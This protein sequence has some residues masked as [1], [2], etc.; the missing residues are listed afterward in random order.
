MRL[1]RPS[2]AGVT[3]CERTAES[4][5]LRH[6]CKLVAIGACSF[7]T[8]GHD[9][10]AQPQRSFQSPTGILCLS[11]SS[12]H[13]TTPCA[14]VQRERPLSFEAVVKCGCMG[15]QLA[16]LDSLCAV[17]DNKLAVEAGRQEDS[18]CWICL[19]RVLRS[20]P[21]LD[22]AWNGRCQRCVIQ[23]AGGIGWCVYCKTASG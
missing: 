8:T 3:E 4:D 22:R 16:E 17:W 11:D 6:I 2:R 19:V 12:Y 14:G 10:M 7:G 23:H 13:T 9:C 21:V 18:R 15:G 1:W 5:P 20:A